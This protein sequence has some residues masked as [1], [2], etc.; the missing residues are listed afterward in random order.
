MSGIQ[1]LRFRRPIEKDQN[2]YAPKPVAARHTGILQDQLRRCVMGPQIGHSCVLKCSHSRAARPPW[3]PGFSVAVRILLIFRVTAAMYSNIQDCDEGPSTRRSFWTSSLRV[4]SSQYSTTGSL[5]ITCI[6]VMAFRPGRH[7]R[8]TQFGA[9]RTPSCGSYHLRSST[10][11]CAR[12][13]KY[14]R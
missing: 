13:E 1:T 7:R 3:V 11:Y 8:S 9:G 12:Q 10:G 6:K 5:C 14:A 4:T 2:E